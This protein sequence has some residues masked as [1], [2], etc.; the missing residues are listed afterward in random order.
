MS[1]E[2]KNKEPLCLKNPFEVS[3]FP[4]R[5]ESSNQT[6]WKSATKEEVGNPGSWIPACA[7]MTVSGFKDTVDYLGKAA[8]N[9]V[10]E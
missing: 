2:A 4:R 7:G 3:S 5:R 9:T 10:F 8:M 1:M 6:W